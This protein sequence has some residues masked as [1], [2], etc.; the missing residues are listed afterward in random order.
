M[1]IFHLQVLFHEKINPRIAH[2][3]PKQIWYKHC[4]TNLAGDDVSD[5]V[6]VRNEVCRRTK[7]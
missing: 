2:V 6:I 4:A 5:D 1:A 7:K 3:N